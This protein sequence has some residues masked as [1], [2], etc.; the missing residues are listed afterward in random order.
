[1]RHFV[2]I[3]LICALASPAAACDVAL[4]LAVDVSGSISSGEYTLQMQGLAEALQVDD[5]I[6]ALVA[7]Q[8]ELALVQWSGSG[9]QQFSLPWV[10]IGTVADVAGLAAVIRTKP[11][12][13]NYTDTAIGQAVHF[14][15]AQ[16]AAVPE[17]RRH[18]IDVSGD[19]E[20]NDG[21]TLSAARAEAKALG[22]T[23]NG[24]AIETGAGTTRLTDYYRQFVATTDGFVMTA[25]GLQDFPR[26]I[27]AKLLRELTKP[28]S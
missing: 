20:E 27:H 5:I 2:L 25:E 18:V 6:K 19:G 15:I 26:A 9:Y 7:G 14:S 21:M 8:D 16:F 23:V 1:M 22:D 12:P 11:R 10:R 28:V 24:V 17:C 13:G 4:L 3:L